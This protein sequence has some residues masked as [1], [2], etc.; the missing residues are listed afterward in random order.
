[1]PTTASSS[2]LRRLLT[3][4]GMLRAPGVFDGISA[5]LAR[6]AGFRAAYLTGAGAVASG[7]GLP[8]IG[9]ATATEMADRAALVV[10]A[11]GLPVIADADTG[12]GNPMHVVRTMRAYERAGVAAIQLEDQDFPKRCG[13]LDDKSVVGTDDFVRK[14]VAAL[15]A[16]QDDTVVIARTDARGPMGLDEALARADRYAA[17]GADM[18]FVEAPASREEIERIAAEV[19][20][21][22]VFNVVPSGRTPAIP[23]ADLEKLGYRLAIYPGAVLQPAAQAMAAA[24][25]DLGGED[26]HVAEGP[27]GLFRTVGLDEWTAISDRYR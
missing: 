8:D 10:E 11:S 9:L 23:D 6:R 5:H 14:L 13:H 7:H 27:A 4:P 18:I 22:L 17:E 3:E 26:P 25:V 12:Y 16:R 1:M 21:P 15:E 19:K 24:L 20:A 2:E